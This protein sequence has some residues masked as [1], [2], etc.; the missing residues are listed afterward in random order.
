MKRAN[1]FIIGL[2]LLSLSF[3]MQKAEA[4]LLGHWTFDEGAGTTAY[5]SADG[6]DGTIFGA[7]WTAGQIAGALDFDGDGDYVN[8]GNDSGLQIEGEFTVSAW[9]CPTDSSTNIEW[10]DPIVSKENFRKGYQLTW[11]PD[12]KFGFM[13]SGSGAAHIV[14]GDPGKD[15]D[16]CYLVTGVYDGATAHIYVNGQSENSAV[17]PYTTNTEDNFY[18]G[19]WRPDDSTR[20]RFFD[21]I[22]DDVRIYDHAL[23]EEEVAQLAMLPDT[24]GDGIS[25]GADN[26]PLTPNPSQDDTDGDGSG[27]ACDNCPLPNP[28]QRDDDENGIGD[29]CDQLAEFLVDEGF[30][31]RPDVSLDH[32]GSP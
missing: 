22:I 28:D 26:C 31:K 4:G 24:D 29:V 25:D 6:H 8:C 9:A 12:G 13:V 7:A 17:E 1:S 23:T 3:S 19:S 20:R 32:G 14:W 18:I 11:G 21:G 16:Q 2:A 5:D 30:I 15:L 10:G 27:D